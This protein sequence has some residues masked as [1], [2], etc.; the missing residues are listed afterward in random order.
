[1]RLLVKSTVTHTISIPPQAG[2]SKALEAF[3]SGLS[4]ATMRLTLQS[5]VNFLKDVMGTD[6]QKM[7]MRCS[8]GN[9]SIPLEPSDFLF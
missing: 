8:K 3:S 6:C 2:H 4:N 7:P 1:M 9:L 5:A